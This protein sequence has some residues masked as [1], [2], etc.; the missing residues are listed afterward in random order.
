V[1]DEKNAT[2][3]ASLFLEF[4]HVGLKKGFFNVALFCFCHVGLERRGFLIWLLLIKKDFGQGPLSV[5]FLPA[6]VLLQHKRRC[7]SLFHGSM[8]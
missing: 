3:V 8:I 6:L 2:S 4:S 7:I 5:L 1:D